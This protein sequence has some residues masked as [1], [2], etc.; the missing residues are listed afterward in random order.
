MDKR[1][2]GP[3]RGSHGHLFWSDVYADGATKTVLVHRE[4]MEEHLGRPLGRKEVIHHRNGDPGDNRI[5]NL[6]VMKWREHSSH[7]A[8]KPEISILLCPQCGEP[9][10]ARMRHVRHNR[11]QGKA[12]PFCGKRC[13]GKYSA[14]FSG[15]KIHAAISDGGRRILRAKHGS[16][17]MY[18]Y[19]RCRCGICRAWNAQRQANR[20][21]SLAGGTRNT[22]TS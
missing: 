13:A 9:F 17:S 19:H 10:E 22:R 6:Q 4:K 2:Y 5:E 7:H 14:A 3:Y 16:A 18:K 20:R 15:S 12:G 11:K 8:R 21:S 1:R